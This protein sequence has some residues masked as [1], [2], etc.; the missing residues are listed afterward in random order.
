MVSRAYFIVSCNVVT[1]LF[2][3]MSAFIRLG[4]AKEC[5]VLKKMCLIGDTLQFTKV[6]FTP[7]KK[8]VS[9]GNSTVLFGQNCVSSL[10]TFAPLLSVSATA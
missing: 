9:L 4:K 6:A 8:N 1:G 2:L 3:L 5:D 7:L 10:L